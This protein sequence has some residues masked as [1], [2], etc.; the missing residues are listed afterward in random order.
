MN[1]RHFLTGM[2]AALLTAHTRFLFAAPPRPT[3][4]PLWPGTPPGGGG[5]TGPIVLSAKGA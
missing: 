2:T 3:I 1:R 5:P 4:L